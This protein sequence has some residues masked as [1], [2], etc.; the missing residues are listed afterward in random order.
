MKVDSKD[1]Q[2]EDDALKLPKHGPA[3]WYM[4]KLSLGFQNNMDLPSRPI[5]LQ[6]EL[7]L[8]PK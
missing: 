2:G 5:D 6:Q 1:Q 3:L 8:T 7:T 4:I